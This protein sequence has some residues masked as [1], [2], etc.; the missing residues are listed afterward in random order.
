MNPSTIFQVAT[1]MVMVQWLLMIVAPRWSV[2]QWLMKSML[3]PVAIAV[4]YTFY[5]GTGGPVNF[6]DFG[7]LEGVKKL[8]ASATDGTMLAG[9]VHYLAFDLAVGTWM[10]RQS[11]DKAI[12]HW[13]M[14]PCLFCCFMAG[15][16]GLL[17]YWVVRSIKTKS[18]TA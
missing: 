17:L 9:W 6:G 18:L 4:I 1:N 15:P 14:I 11:Q 12:S 3:I 8:F 2:T 5:L 16:V 13:L 10:L 7:S